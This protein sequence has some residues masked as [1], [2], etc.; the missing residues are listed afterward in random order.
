MKINKMETVFRELNP[1][2]NPK[3]SEFDD[4]ALSRLFAEVVKNVLR[5]N[6]TQKSWNYY[7]GTRWIRDEGN[8]KA[9]KHMKRFAR[10]V[11]NYAADFTRYMK[12][13]QSIQN[14]NTRRR[15][16]DDARECYAF[17]SEELDAQENLLNCQNG[18]LDL[19]SFE[20]LPHN[21]DLLLS[22]LANVYYN[23]NAKGELW[24]KTNREIFQNDESCIRFNHQFLGLSLT[25]NTAEEKFLMWLGTTTR[26]GKSTIGDTV[27]YMMGDY[28]CTIQPETLMQRVKDGRQASGDIARLRGVRLVMTSEPDK[29]S[30]YDVSLLK[31]LTGGDRI[32][33]R[34]L[35]EREIEFNPVLKLI[36]NTNYLPVVSDSTL[37]DSDRVIVLPF[38][39]H[40]KPEE[41]DKELKRKLK[42]KENLS[43]VLNCLLDGLKDYR[44]NGL[45]YPDKVIEASEEYANREDKMSMFFSDMASNFTGDGKFANQRYWSIKDA[46]EEFAKW[47]DDSG[48][49]KESKKNFIEEVKK[50]RCFRDKGY[51]FGVQKD[52]VIDLD[53]LRAKV[54]T[55][56]PSIP[57]FPDD[58][59]EVQEI[60]F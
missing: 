35:Q 39:R 22:K 44:E 18:V 21:P 4:I 8:M 27:V 34:H 6:T 30:S 19:N 32:T 20:L 29:K 12:I 33:A 51:C 26:N 1:A 50:R 16:L 23:K 46:Y 52:R 45:V 13:A 36:V 2:E 41:R 25:C 43:G 31:Q 37:F 54:P 53:R 48:F 47:C 14:A 17:C 38:E 9:S 15:L 42:S 57:A 11:W 56:A 24:K 59:T 49:R 28:A 55:R 7:D 60:Q 5:Y 58:N 10:I 40:F 3:Y